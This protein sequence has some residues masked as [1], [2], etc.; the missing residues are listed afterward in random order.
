[1]EISLFNGKKL[2]LG[3]PIPGIIMITAISFNSKSKHYQKNRKDTKTF[4]DPHCML[5]LYCSYIF[6]LI[7][8]FVH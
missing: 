5:L 1:M 2:F 8:Q 3:I 4:M 6:F 7:Y